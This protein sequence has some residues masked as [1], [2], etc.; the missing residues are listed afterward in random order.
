MKSKGT[1]LSLLVILTLVAVVVVT[2][3][4]PAAPSGPNTGPIV[5]G[6]VGAAAGPGTKPCID[7]QAMAVE[8]INAAGGILGRPVKFVVEDSKGEASL[9]VAGVTRLVMGSKVTAYSV[10]GLT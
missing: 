2:G 7:A 5:I 10:E 9:T 6:Y 4:A 1:I 3:C 8:E